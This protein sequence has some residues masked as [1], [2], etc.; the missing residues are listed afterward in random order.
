MGTIQI[1]QRSFIDVRLK[2]SVV[3][4]GA[5]CLTGCRQSDESIVDDA[6][7]V[8]DGKVA[9][10]ET[11]ATFCGAC[12]AV[13]SPGMFPREQWPHEVQLGFDFYYQSQ[14]SDLTVP[15]IESV[16]SYYQQLAPETISFDSS[17][18][19]PSSKVQFS[20][21]SVSVSDDDSRMPAVSHLG[22]LDGAHPGLIQSDMRS[23][24][25]H[26]IEFLKRDRYRIEQLCNAKHPA[27]CTSV[28]L[29]SDGRLEYVVADLGSFLPS[30]HNLGRVLWVRA[31]DTTKQASPT[32]LL[33]HVGR[34]SD[35]RGVDFDSDGDQDLLVAEFGWR[36]S[37]GIFWLEQIGWE[38]NQPK[39][40]KHQID[41][42]HGTIHVPVF[43]WND[44]GRLDFAAAIS[45]E[46]ETVDV[47]VN[48][49]DGQFET[50]NAFAAK[51]P[52]YGT[53]GIELCDLDGDGDLDILLTN[54]DSFDSVALS[55]AH[56]IQWLENHDGKSFTH[57]SL[58]SMPGV[59]R[60]IP[61]DLDNDGDLDI[62]ACAFLPERLMPESVGRFDGLI[63][64]EQTE[65]G[66]F[67]RHRVASLPP[68]FVALQTGDFDQ[69][70]RIDVAAGRFVF[71]ESQDG[72][73]AIFWNDS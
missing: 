21:S 66:R 20:R 48:H 46:H 54:G 44:D 63:W 55:P 5:F 71:Q 42:R 68:E 30:D 47:F 12:H 53:S 49:G 28:D 38:N 37:G 8:S 1:S 6:S 31:T 4:F 69:D 60:A 7:T 72:A 27:R 3:L 65:I 56:S 59:H 33:E 52:S 58:T 29:N 36:Q 26:R 35:V 2:L 10:Q 40:A 51:E 9:T 43:D 17:E 19:L 32:V 16:V 18:N 41:F 67:V 62:V 13:P 70:G 14:R 25:V 34:V 11:V 22:S 61:A 64:L 15:S 39:L 73:L 57:H 23:G 50:V 45:Q 24:S